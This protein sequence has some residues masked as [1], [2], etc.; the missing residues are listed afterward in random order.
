MLEKIP[1]LGFPI[2]SP[3]LGQA[4][5]PAQLGVGCKVG[6]GWE[7]KKPKTELKWALVDDPAFGTVSRLYNYNVLQYFAP[8]Y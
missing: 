3:P 2:Q 4:T 5:L 8:F 6:V 7:V 1:K